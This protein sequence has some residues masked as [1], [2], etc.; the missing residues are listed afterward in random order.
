[1]I[2]QFRGDRNAPYFAR[3]MAERR[4]FRDDWKLQYFPRLRSALE[5]DSV[6]E[7]ACG[8][9]SLAMECLE[10]TACAA[11]FL[12]DSGDPTKEHGIEERALIVN[13]MEP[14]CLL[15]D[16]VDNELGNL[17]IFEPSRIVT[18]HLSE[19][20][21]NDA[22]TNYASAWNEVARE[23]ARL[24]MEK[25]LSAGRGIAFKNENHFSELQ[26]S[27]NILRSQIVAGRNITKAEMLDFLSLIAR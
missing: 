18:L 9:R 19:K 21:F 3:M 11:E 2:N 22:M 15:A 10:T 16:F 4:N 14:G 12:R 27:A 7:Q 17:I 8:M 20:Y 6:L 26:S 5:K 1:M 23:M 13:A 25:Y 24:G